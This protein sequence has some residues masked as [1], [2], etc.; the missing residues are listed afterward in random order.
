MNMTPL[1]LYSLRECA[2]LDSLF[3]RELQM[4]DVWKI[5]PQQS[6]LT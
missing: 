5:I 6:Y 1:G 4:A 2:K 3:H